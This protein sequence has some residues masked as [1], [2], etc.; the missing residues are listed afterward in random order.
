MN[1][2]VIND[3]DVI[4]FH[5]FLESFYFIIFFILLFLYFLMIVSFYLTQIFLLQTN[6]S[7]NLK[8]QGIS[9]TYLLILNIRHQNLDLETISPKV[10]Y[11]K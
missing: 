11:L 6:F 10:K 7:N 9:Q 1:F 5:L 2:I 8:Y 4:S 3:Q